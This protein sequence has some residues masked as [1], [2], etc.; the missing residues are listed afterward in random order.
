MGFRTKQIQ[1]HALPL[2]DLSRG[3]HLMRN[4]ALTKAAP[5]FEIHHLKTDLRQ[6][7]R[8][9]L[10]FGYRYSEKA[11]QMLLEHPRVQRSDDRQRG[12]LIHLRRIKQPQEH[13]G[14]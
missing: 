10:T 9:V 12:T 11:T 14:I 13:C 2:N 4:N 5:S 3:G 8:V 7:L 6:I 1:R